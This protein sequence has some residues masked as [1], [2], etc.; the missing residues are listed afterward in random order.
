MHWQPPAAFD[1]FELIRHIGTGGMGTV[2]LAQDTVLGRQVAIKFVS[3]TAA[4][5]AA[6]ARFALEARAIARL[7]H[8]NVVAVYR[9]GGVGGCPY[10]A[11]EYVDGRRLDRLPRP[12]EWQR[13]LAIG[14]GLARELAAAHQAGVLHR[15]IKPANVMVTAAGEVKLLDF[16]LAK[17]SGF[18]PPAA[19]A[20]APREPAAEDDRSTPPVGTDEP[21]PSRPSAAPTL[22]ASP[23]HA[24]PRRENRLTV[25]G[26][27]VGTPLYIAPELWEDAPSSERTDLYALGMVL[28]ELLAGSLPLA[29]LA[30]EALARAA[31]V[32]DTP[33]LADLLPVVP[34]SLTRLID[35]CV[36]RRPEGRPR[37]AAEVRDAL[38]ALSALYRPFVGHD[39]DGERDAALLSESFVRVQ[40][41]D[42]DLA[43]DFYERWFAADPAIRPLF[44]ADLVQQR[45]MLTAA[46]KLA[47]DN[48]RS[49][50]KLV[51]LL[52]DLGRRHA[53]YGAQADQF[54]TMGHALMA[55]LAEL[56]LEWSPATERAWSAA[57]ARITQVVQRSMEAELAS[58]SGLVVGVGRARLDLPL[59]QPRTQWARRDDVEVAYQVIGHG[60][61]DLLVVGEWVTHLE[62]LWRHVA[63][64]AFIR[65]LA[66]LARV[67]VLDR[68]PCGLSDGAAAP[69]LDASLEDI[70]TVLDAVGADQPVVLGVGDGALVAA[71]LAATTP[72]RVRALVLLGSGARV[73]PP[74]EPEAVRDRLARARGLVRERWGGPLFVEEHAPSLAADP[75]YRRWWA[76]N[77]RNG[78]GPA[79]ARRLLD[80]AVRLDITALAP[81]VQ[82]PTL[83][84][85]RVGDRICSIDQARR[86]AAVIPGARLVELPG[87][88]HAPWAGDLEQLLDPLH[89]FLVDL[90]TGQ[91]HTLIAA[92]ALA[93]QLRG[94]RTAREAFAAAARRE[95]ARHQGVPFGPDDGDARLALF[96]VPGRAIRCARALA[97]LGLPIALGVET[98][99]L[100][101]G[102]ALSGPALDQAA[103][104]AR[105][106]AVGEVALGPTILGLG[107]D[108]SRSDLPT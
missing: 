22:V 57:I 38:E 80:L 45:R 92:T 104:L 9:V 55:S 2:Y 46:L 89:E 41:G 47:I 8:P 18:S 28:Y 85:H 20:T 31:L 58:H 106:A 4:D 100:H 50:E 71:A 15:D 103:A 19:P 82:A 33:L 64:A 6:A 34:R 98:G 21:D 75:T 105:A 68:R 7:H 53:R 54:S 13:V 56:D 101:A 108:A 52:E 3:Q 65:R 87:D 29:H 93:V 78:A 88:D 14:L 1:D 40:S 73:R 44:G 10:I 107:C 66:A 83:L 90:P 24:A 70:L 79:T 37:S 63:P 95:F 11:Y 84:L 39:D 17:L 51:P 12:M 99:P 49:P 5:P 25:A 81:A 16:G 86:L 32:T 77:L 48:L 96:E 61:I 27:V 42:E 36:R 62:C 91:A 60:P 43:A 97:A 76:A 26:T 30:G 94:P 35:R 72:G 102:V 69:S 23:V 74:G 67:I 59:A